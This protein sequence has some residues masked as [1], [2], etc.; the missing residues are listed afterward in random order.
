MSSTLL[1]D[2][3]QDC[4]LS[5]ASFLTFQIF[6]SW[7]NFS[8]NLSVF[9]LFPFSFFF[10]NEGP[11]PSL[12]YFHQPWKY[13]S[14]IP[15]FSCYSPS[16]C[17]TVSGCQQRVWFI[18]Q[19]LVGQG[20]PHGTPGPRGGSS[21]GAPYPPDSGDSR[22]EVNLANTPRTGDHTTINAS[23]AGER[24][25]TGDRRGCQRAAAHWT[26]HAWAVF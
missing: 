8:F 12:I 23:F 7:G 3:A 5:T 6:N 15:L 13:L 24:R 2:A 25:K 19:V 21:R 17:F 4:L 16:S 14:W 1:P 9:K 22:W 11:P 26:S 18:Y 10:L 20:L